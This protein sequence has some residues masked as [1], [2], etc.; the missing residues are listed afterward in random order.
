MST[1]SNINDVL[2][3]MREQ[4]RQHL[5]VKL[6]EISAMWE[7]LQHAEKLDADS[8]Q[9]LYRLV[10]SLTGSGAT[11]G[12]TAL[13]EMARILETTISE[14]VKNAEQITEE[15]KKRIN[16]QWH[17]VMLA[18]DR[19]DAESP[20]HSDKSG[21]TETSNPVAPVKK[22]KGY[23]L[24]VEDDAD[25][26][27]N[28]ELQLGHFGYSVKVLHDTMLLTAAVAEKTPMV[29]I[30]DVVFPEGAI[31]GPLAV[32]GLSD[33]IKAVIPV[34]FLSSRG[35][36]NARLSAVRAGAAAYF[37][38]PVD[39]GVLIDKLDS[40]TSEVLPEAFKVLIVDDSPSLASFYALTLQSAGMETLVVT[41]PF[42]MLDAISDFTPELILLDMYMPGCSGMEL[43]KIIRQQESLVSTPIV[44]LSAETNMDKQLEAMQFGADD[45]L[46]KPIQADHL[47]S[48]VTSKVQRYRTLRT[49][50]VRDSLTG[51][52]N[53]TKT[54]EE[55]DVEIMR[56][57]RQKSMLVFAMI[58]IDF[59]KKVNDTYGHATG[60]RV[61]KS[62]SRLLQQRLRKTDIIGRYG[63][64]E[65]AVVLRD[66]DG[67]S[68]F[69]ALD[70]IRKA[71]EQIAQYSE[72]GGE[73]FSVTFSC[74]LAE[75]PGFSNAPEIS[76]AA[77]K[78]LY[79]AKRGGRNRVVMARKSEKK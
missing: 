50:M 56:A 57:E 62:L 53:H 5:P 1:P 46:T 18:A 74:G 39:I 44:F 38:K 64:E 21:E 26:A 51:L 58:D 42:K 52:L 11:F 63:G 67:P 19:P 8:V 7:S 48:A 68:A 28:I 41:D 43:A 14:N 34:I 15:I 40:L 9:T 55:L 23:V 77:D 13:S 76:N 60:D 6:A 30:M 73:N 22:E 61:I 12:L 49:F 65:F 33:E 10:H 29:I 16:A 59:F 20:Q 25:Q 2:R 24:L 32:I 54:K 31:A 69:T 75:F 37:T 45:F 3:E 79:E 71:F 47:I 72:S 66:T 36:L 27:R 17:D 4:Y 35:D 70:N 78:A